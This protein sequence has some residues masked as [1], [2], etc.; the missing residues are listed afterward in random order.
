[1]L[2]LQ[3][4]GEVPAI[5][6]LDH[7][8]WKGQLQLLQSAKTRVNEG[9]YKWREVVNMIDSIRVARA[10]LKHP[11]Q[12]FDQIFRAQKEAA[13]KAKKLARQVAKQRE[14]ASE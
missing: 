5:K 11:P 14:A 2:S 3:G 13:K 4:L 9:E 7:S 6:D 12:P 8:P 10:K 1:M